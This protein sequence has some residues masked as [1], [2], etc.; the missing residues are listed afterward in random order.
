MKYRFVYDDSYSEMNFF[1]LTGEEASLVAV[2]VAGG[3]NTIL[4]GAQPERLVKAIKALTITNRPIEVVDKDMTFEDFLGVGSTGKVG[5]MI[6]ANKGIL[7]V[8]DLESMRGTCKEMLRAI[9]HNKEVRLCSRDDIK[10]YPADFQLVA[11]MNP[12]FVVRQPLGMSS[13]KLLFDSCGIIYKCKEDTERMKY[14][15]KDLQNYVRNIDKHRQYYYGENCIRDCDVSDIEEI[16]FTT[17]AKEK[18]FKEVV[19]NENLKDAAWQIGRVAKTVGLLNGNSK[20]K[21]ANVESAINLHSVTE[22]V[23]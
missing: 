17:G 4:C 15:R 20:T 13:Y 11:T 6:R 3:H 21:I 10:T 2:A 7:F 18:Y 19:E 5:A 12:N 22:F 16:N 14:T 9:I 8:N 1:Y 23:M